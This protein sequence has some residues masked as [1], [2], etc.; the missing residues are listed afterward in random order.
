M[1]PQ[2]DVLSKNKKKKYLKVSDGIFNYFFFQL[3]N[4]CL[5]GQFS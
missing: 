3:K 1:Y 5:H 2:I 4:L